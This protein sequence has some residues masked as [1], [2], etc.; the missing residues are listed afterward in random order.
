MGAR[1]DR[2]LV[3]SARDGDQSA[4]VDLVRARGDRWFAI[5]HRILREVDRAEDALQD[6]LVIAWRDLPDLRDPDRFDAWIH[7]ILMNVCIAHASR[8]RRRL[9]HIRVL[10]ID[11]PRSPDDMLSVADRDQLD[12]AFRRLTPEERAILVLRHY[13]G[14][15]PSEIADV[16]GQP[17]G[18]VRSRLHHAH[19][20]M[21]AAIDADER[22][23]AVGG[24]SA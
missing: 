17:A 14:Y 11:V 3:E 21:R 24:S 9:A 22:A 16:L 18:T 6:A 20:A 7:R 10:T 5:A 1:V 23:A 8:E 12:R 13:I 15:E 4:F 19:R 2:D